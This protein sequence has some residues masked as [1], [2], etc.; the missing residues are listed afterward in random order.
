MIGLSSVTS[1]QFR[2]AEAAMSGWVRGA[3]KPQSRR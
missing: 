1:P 2:L 3:D